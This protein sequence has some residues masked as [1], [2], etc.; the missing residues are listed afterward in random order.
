[1]FDRLL[2]VCD[3]KAGEALSGA[4]SV[5]SVAACARQCDDHD[6]CDGFDTNGTQCYLKSSCPAARQ[7]SSLCSNMGSWCGY[8]RT[9]WDARPR[10]G[11]L[12]DTVVVTQTHLVTPAAIKR[13]ALAQSQLRA[14]GARHFVALLIGDE[15]GGR[16]RCDDARHPRAAD[17]ATLRAAL[18]ADAVWCVDP[19][20]F[21][22]RWPDF[23]ARTAALPWKHELPASNKGR[24]VPPPHWRY[25]T[26]SNSLGWHWSW[27]NCDLPGPLGALESLPQ[28][29]SWRWL[30]TLDWDV[31]WTGDLGRILAAFAGAPHDYLAAYAPHR[32]D[33]GSWPYFGLRSH[34]RDDEVWQTLVVPQRFSRRLLRVMDA[35]IAAGNHSFCEMRAPSL[36]A[37][38]REWCTQARTPPPPVPSL[39]VPLPLP[40]GAYAPSLRAAGGNG[41]AAAERPW[42]VRLLQHDHRGAARRDGAAVARAAAH[43]RRRAL[44]GAAAA[45]RARHQE[46]EH[47]G[48]LHARHQGPLPE[49]QGQA[50]PRG[51]QGGQGRRRRQAQG[52]EGR[53][54]WVQEERPWLGGKPRGRWRRRR[55]R[56][57]RSRR[58]E[59]PRSSSGCSSG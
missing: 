2:S 47:G 54:V 44:A 42:R 4:R 52:G 11:A 59:E 23:F 57:A 25:R 45:P 56:A 20:L 32:A 21:Q 36:C 43:R 39:R 53:Q 27:V 16:D 15:P 22:R 58:G 46:D 3:S 28:D 30:W 37:Q 38:Q 55:R 12:A 14:V 1:M 8:Q 40:V 41:R 33:R 31:G 18:G 19:P 50:R 6:A 35:G 13:F 49:G 34:L 48:A 17:L 7:P 10:P 9:S 26:T 5:D 24:R 29:G 51:Q